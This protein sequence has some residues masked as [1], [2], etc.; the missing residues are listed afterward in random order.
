M[1]V[2]GLPGPFYHASRLRCTELSSKARDRMRYLRCFEALWGEGL[3]G[4][5]ASEV[6]DIPR[7]TLYRWWRRLQGGGPGALEDRSR[8]PKR[9]RVPTWSSELAQAV[10]RLREQCPRWG[11]DKLVVLLWRRGWEVS[12]SMVGRILS[13]LKARLPHRVFCTF[14]GYQAQHP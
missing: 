2:V 8:R 14:C 4:T 3:S 10:L 5:K 7:S 13:R 11:K 9:R 1:Q 12:V 6:L